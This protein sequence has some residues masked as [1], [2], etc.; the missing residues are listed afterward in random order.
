M[1]V[2]ITRKIPEVGIKKLRD[3]GIEILE[4]EE[5]RELTPPELIKYCKSLLGQKENSVN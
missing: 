3:E 4:W 5:K 1:K 2:F